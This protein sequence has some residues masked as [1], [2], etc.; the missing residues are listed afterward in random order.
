VRLLLD[1]N[2]SA[3]SLIERLRNV[4]HDAV[5]S[6]ELVGLGARDEYVVEAAVAQRRVLVTRDCDD[7]RSLYGEL[8]DHPGLLLIYGFEQKA[9][10]TDSLVNALNNVANIYP[11]LDN[12][13]L[14]LN[15]FVW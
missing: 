4:G 9:T 14:T 8:S 12:L 3:R 2:A 11:T 10:A 15:D 1:E 13:V 6:V 5:T 7:F